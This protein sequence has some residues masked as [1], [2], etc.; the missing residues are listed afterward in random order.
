ME[1]VTGI[2]AAFDLMCKALAVD[3]DAGHRFSRA[4]FVVFFEDEHKTAPEVVEQAWRYYTEEINGPDIGKVKNKFGKI[5][6]KAK[7]V[8]GNS[9]DAEQW[10]LYPAMGLSGYRPIDLLTTNEGTQLV[11]DFLGRMEYCVYT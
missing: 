8:F 4:D 5:M 11:E 1:N 9:D 7:Q 3:A 10:L 6:A 2:R